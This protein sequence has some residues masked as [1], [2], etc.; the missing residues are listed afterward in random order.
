MPPDGAGNEMDVFHFDES[1]PSFE[2][3]GHDGDSRYWYARN[4]TVMLG[5]R[6][7]QRFPERDE[8]GSG[9][10]TTMGIPAAPLIHQNRCVDKNV[11]AGE[12]PRP[13]IA[14]IPDISV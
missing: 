9:T 14:G 7:L 3:L 6:K 8:Q 12:P 11:A 5:A 4:L 13:A 1:R 10:C 2:D